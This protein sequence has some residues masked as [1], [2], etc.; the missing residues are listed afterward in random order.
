MPRLGKSNSSLSANNIG[1]EYT[2][3]ESEFLKEMDFFIRT[4]GKKFPTFTDVFNIVKS[5]GYT[6]APPPSSPTGELSNASN[7]NTITA[8]I[9]EAGN[10][11]DSTD[12]LTARRV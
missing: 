1:S 7:G 11:G 2:D 5:L 3:E 6:K 9:I 12:P 4:S 8:D 10:G